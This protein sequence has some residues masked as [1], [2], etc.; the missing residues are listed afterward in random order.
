MVNGKEG[1]HPLTDIIDH[2]LDIFS[3]EIDGKVRDLAPGSLP[4]R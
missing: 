4:T 2:G 3:A 1:D